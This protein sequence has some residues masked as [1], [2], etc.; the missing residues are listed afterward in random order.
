[1]LSIPAQKD[2][3][4]QRVGRNNHRALRRMFYRYKTGAM[5]YAYYTLRLHGSA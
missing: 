1:M 3:T 4:M 5:R 2:S